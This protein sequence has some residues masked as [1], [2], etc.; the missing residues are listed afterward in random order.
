[1]EYRPFVLLGLVAT[2]AGLAC[3]GTVQAPASDRSTAWGYLSL[4]PRDGVTVSKTPGGYGDRR[5]RSVTLVD[6]S[7][8][9]FAVVYTPG[10]P[11]R[12]RGDIEL[13]IVEGRSGIAIEPSQAAASAG[14][15]LVV[16]NRSSSPR[17]LSCP[18]SALV[19]ELRSGE[20]VSVDL[21]KAGEYAVFLLDVPEATSTVFAAPGAWVVVSESGRWQLD[22]LDPGRR[23]LHAWHPRLP[24][25]SRT[26]ELSPGAVHRL[27]LEVGVGR[28]GSEEAD[29]N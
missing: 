24:P 7:R 28:S 25:T 16:T 21:A 4:V 27:D 5:M 2:A 6:Y 22:D 17:V 19:R 10:E 20:Q 14:G 15:R 3:A 11:S 29:A 12:A 1:M 18:G 9:G 8:P 26:V 13:S 23:E